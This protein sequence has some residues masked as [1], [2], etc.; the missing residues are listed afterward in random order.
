MGDIT[1]LE[2]NENSSAVTEPGLFE[3]Y[4]TFPIWMLKAI[5]LATPDFLLVQKQSQETKK[6]SHSR[7]A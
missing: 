2:T 3:S 1:K 4:G 5:Q 6:N 7:T